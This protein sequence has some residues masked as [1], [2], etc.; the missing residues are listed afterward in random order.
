MLGRGLWT[1]VAKARWD[2]KR[3]VFNG[4][5]LVLVLVMDLRI[6]WRVN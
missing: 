1:T 3:V 4:D 5:A 2:G 6:S